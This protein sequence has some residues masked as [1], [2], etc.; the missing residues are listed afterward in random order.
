MSLRIT[1]ASMEAIKSFFF[2][3]EE[4]VCYHI[5]GFLGCTYNRNTYLKRLENNEI[6]KGPYFQKAM[7]VGNELNNTNKNVQVNINY[8]PRQTWRQDVKTIVEVAPS[9]YLSFLL[10]HM[11][12]LSYLSLF[13]FFHFLRFLIFFSLT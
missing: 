2:K 12:F 7:C 3:K 1:A 11:P 13:R 8:S 5:Y 4:P 9:F 10:Y 6:L